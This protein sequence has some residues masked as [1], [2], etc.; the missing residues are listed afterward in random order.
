MRYNEIINEEIEVSGNDKNTMYEAA[1][2]IL[3]ECKPYLSQVT[4]PLSLY[5]GMGNRH[6]PF[7]KKSIRQENRTPKLM[8]QR[9]HDYIN[10]YFSDEFGIPFRNALFVLG[11]DNRASIFGAVHHIFPIGNF[12]FLWSP[13]VEDLNYSIRD[14]LKLQQTFDAADG[15]EAEAYEWSDTGSP[16]QERGIRNAMS[17]VDYQTTDLQGAIEHGRYENTKGDTEIMIYGQSYYAI[18]T[19]YAKMSGF[20]KILEKVLQ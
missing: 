11:N 4:N 13:K 15:T 12:K 18:S 14:M 7:I 5:R 1:H 6:Q 17:R 9:W 2:A 19:D 16:A 3:D 20:D 10:A 8:R